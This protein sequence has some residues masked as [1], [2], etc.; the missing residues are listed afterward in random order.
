MAFPQ[1][2]LLIIIFKHIMNHCDSKGISVDEQHGLRSRRS[3]ETQLI[4]ALEDIARKRNKGSN[5]DLL[6]LDI[7]KAFDTVPHQRLMSK[8]DHYGIRGSTDIGR[9]TR[10]WLWDRKQQVVV[11]GETSVRVESGASGDSAGPLAILA[12][13]KGCNYGNRLPPKTIC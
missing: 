2:D 4:T 8:L 9:W 13:Y 3:C 6:I 1:H 7:G 12:F 5:V 11:D 10:A